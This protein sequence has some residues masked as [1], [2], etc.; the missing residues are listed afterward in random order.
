M[1]IFFSF[2]I[3]DDDQSLKLTLMQPWLLNVSDF[4]FLA[5]A[6]ESWWPV[7][8]LPISASHW[9]CAVSVLVIAELAR[10]RRW[11]RNLQPNFC[12][13]LGLNLEPHDWQSSSLTT[14]L[15]RTPIDILSIVLILHCM[16][17]SYMLL[18]CSI[19]MWSVG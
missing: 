8:F 19:V 15:P 13:G 5:T 2:D 4:I 17:Y 9:Q 10:G 16:C 3:L 18:L 6:Y 1:W 7:L 12:P 14:R 11:N